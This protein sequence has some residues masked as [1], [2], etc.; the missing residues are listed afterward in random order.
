MSNHGGDVRTKQVHTRNKLWKCNRACQ[1]FLKAGHSQRYFEPD[2]GSLATTVER[3]AGRQQDFFRGQTDDI[4]QTEQDAVED[5]NRVRC[6]EQHRSTVVPWLRE[7][8]I[9]DHLQNLKKDEIRTAIALP[10]PEEE[11]VLQTIVDAIQNLLLQAHHRCFDGP[12]C[13]LTW[14]CRVVLGRF[15]SPQVEMVGKTRAFDPYKK[16]GTLKT[17]FTLAK[18]A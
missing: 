17:Y 10:T 16:P 3:R 11:P 15:Q 5:A 1:R 7:T 2:D 9:A 6:F 12:E 13:M 8:G 4:R 18:R 14:P